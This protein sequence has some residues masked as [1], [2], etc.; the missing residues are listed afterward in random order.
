MNEV[1][2]GD[3][4]YAEY[5]GYQIILTTR[6]GLPGDPSNIIYLEPGVYNSLI[7]FV[8]RINNNVETIKNTCRDTS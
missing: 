8:K 2:L 4:V 1:Y 3:S 6:N 5:D 7:D